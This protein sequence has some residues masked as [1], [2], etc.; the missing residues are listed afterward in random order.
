MPPRTGW[1]HRMDLRFL[2]VLACF[3]LS[4]FA[5]LLY[6]TVWTRQLSFSFGTSNLAVATVLAAYMA[7]M[8]GGSALAARF[9][10]RI[11]RPLLAYGLL[12]A[13]IAASALAVSPA[14]AL[15]GRLHV[16]LLGGVDG[17][18]P[19]TA[20]SSAGFYALASFAILCVPTGLMGATLPLLAEHAVRDDSQLG[21]RVGALYTINTLG[22]VLGVLTTAFVLLPEL[23]LTRTVW[24]GVSLNALVTVFAATLGRAPRPRAAVAAAPEE[25]LAPAA[26]FLAIA[27]GAGIA[28]FALEVLWTR[29]VEHVIGASVYAFASM[30]SS[31]LVGIAGGSALAARLARRRER[32]APGLAVSQLAAGGFALVAYALA[33]Q[34]P[35]LAAG[36][37]GL[38]PR[39]RVL[40]LAAASGLI[41]LPATLAIGATF[42]FAVRAI[43]RGADSAGRS[44][45]RVYA[46]NTVGAIVGSLSAG[47]L[48]IPTLGLRGTLLL[49]VGLNLAIAGLAALKSVPRSRLVLALGAAL[50][51]LMVVL[52]PAPPWTLV[53]STFGGANDG[54]SDGSGV[55]FYR[56]GRAGTVL[57]EESDVGWHL[58]T[59]GLPEAEIATRGEN[60]GRALVARWL[61]ALPALGG[62]VDRM[63]VIGLGG[64]LA[65][66]RLPASIRHVDVVEIEAAVVEANRSIAAE[67][68]RDPLADPR[69]HVSVNDARGAL[70]LTRSRWN[71]IVSQPSHPWTAG[72][73]HL[74]TH[75]F[76][77][78]AASRL[79][80]GG[81]FVQWIGLAFV[82]E[83]LLRR[84]AATLLETFPHVRIYQPSRPGLLFL[85][86]RSP[87]PERSREAQAL[88]T[89]PEVFATLG[90]RRVED[91]EAMLIVDEEG[92]R[93]LAG[94]SEP[95]R[96]DRNAFTTRSPWLTGRT[97]IQQANRLLAGY[98]RLADRAAGLDAQALAVRLARVWPDR[99]ARWVGAVPPGPLRTALAAEL[100]WLRGERESAAAGFRAALERDPSLA[101]A[102]LRLIS[103][104]FAQGE[105]P[106]P[107]L[108]A[109]A[110]APTLA[111]VAGWRARR[112]GDARDVAALDEGLAAVPAGHPA[113]PAA[114]DLRIG[115]RLADGGAAV[116]REGLLLLDEQGGG[117]PQVAALRALF[118]ARAGA[119]DEATYSLRTLPAA[120]A[121][122][123]PALA[124][125][126]RGT[127]EHALSRLEATPTAGIDTTRLREGLQ[128]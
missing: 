52:P 54:P 123:P 30:L 115:W 24:I 62:P 89:A 98:D 77:E 126:A 125:R 72:A 86:S 85:A 104:A 38:G 43:A 94:G 53:R 37:E 92:V 118:A 58:S 120:L 83:L 33:Q 100:R 5:G 119:V 99:F 18:P 17:L 108:V 35:G 9:I 7:G 4:G 101:L 96:D 44:S 112:A 109:G 57:L 113:Q 31:F 97:N 106:D 79:E 40:T 102:R 34:L 61:G 6:E 12:E 128:R 124:A 68:A 11:R 103:L 42:P 81:V 90:A 80:P 82:D 26:A 23:G 13:G 78:L 67:R 105:E 110:D 63:L 14:I 117:G 71:A 25:P 28:S 55:T 70:Q 21:R 84:L 20:F 64:G 73:S 27:C 46:W 49:V 93:E 15:A 127:A 22:A 1:S 39:E 56:V 19:D 66:E 32:A 121:N 48:W 50:V 122:A 74:Y 36:L 47:F 76:Q 91:L 65:V 75:E 59:S 107:A 51:G 87:L 69:V 16:A 10:G 41:L 45:A 60:P 2:S 8:A 95:I 29:L 88:E 114:L 116:S 111:V 3:L